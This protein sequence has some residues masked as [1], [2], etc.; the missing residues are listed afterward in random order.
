MCVQCLWRPEEGDGFLE[1]SMMYIFILNGYGNLYEFIEYC[2]T[3][4]IF[5]GAGV[6]SV[7]MLYEYVY[8]YTHTLSKWCTRELCS[9]P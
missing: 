9:Q 3:S 6:E 5:G 2:L 1:T 7:C 8:V 4:S